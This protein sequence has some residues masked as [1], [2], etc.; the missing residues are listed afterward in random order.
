MKILFIGGPADGEW[1][2]VEQLTSGIVIALP[3]PV[4]H[5]LCADEVSTAVVNPVFYRLEKIVGKFDRHHVYLC[6][7]AVTERCVIEALLNGYKP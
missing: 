4:P 2:E 7:D 1:R 3:T 5:S 6:Q